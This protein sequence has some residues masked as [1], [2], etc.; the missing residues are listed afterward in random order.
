[1]YSKSKK[2]L[3]TVVTW[4]LEKFPDITVKVLD[5]PLP[6]F[7]CGTAF[8]FAFGGFR[9]CYEYIKRKNAFLDMHF[10]FFTLPSFSPVYYFVPMVKCALEPKCEEDRLVLNNYDPMIK[11]TPIFIPNLRRN[12]RVDDYSFKLV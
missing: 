3:G 4:W 5:I 2:S 6:A 1:M 9:V 10:W 8:Y 12:L 7:D 11:A